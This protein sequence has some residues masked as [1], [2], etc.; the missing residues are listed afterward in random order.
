M[1]K[2]VSKFLSL[3]LLSRRFR[4]SCSS[5]VPQGAMLWLQVLRRSAGPATMIQKSGHALAEKRAGPKERA[6]LTEQLSTGIPT[7]FTSPSARPIATPASD[8]FPN[9]D[10]APKTTNTKRNVS[11]DSVSSANPCDTPGW[12]TFVARYDTCR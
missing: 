12:H 10:V 4:F 9:R 5:R 11:K 8:E 3:P 7:I 6:G 1:E 2:R